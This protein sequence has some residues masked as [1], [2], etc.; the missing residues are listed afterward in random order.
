MS[1]KINI[2]I[3]AH[4]TNLN[5]IRDLLKK[6]NTRFIGEDH[7]IDTYFNTPNGRLKLRQGNIE[8]CLIYY[9]RENSAEAKQSNV[10]L[11][12]PNENIIDLKQLLIASLGIK[13]IIDKKREIYV[14]DN[15]KFHLD[16][17]SGL[18][19][20]IEIEAIGESDEDISKLQEQIEYYIKYLLIKKEDLLANSYSDMLKS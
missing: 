9:Q 20:F 7:Q 10:I 16:K 18:G 4:C 19:T 15:I 5:I 17:V 12:H 13:Q 1:K 6:K 14:I 11:Y 2:E 8:K 3:K